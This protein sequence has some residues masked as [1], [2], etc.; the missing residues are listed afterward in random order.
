MA[1]VLS[2][3]HNETSL[4]LKFNPHLYVQPKCTHLE[5]NV[6]MFNA[7]M[8]MNHDSTYINLLHQVKAM[9][10]APWTI[11]E[12]SSMVDGVRASGSDF[13]AWYL[14]NVG[15][16]TTAYET[17]PSDFLETYKTWTYKGV[18]FST[19]VFAP[20]RNT[21]GVLN[22]VLTM[23]FVIEVLMPDG[24]TQEFPAGR[25]L[26][27]Y[28][29][30]LDIS[31]VETETV[32]GFAS[33]SGGIRA[34]L[35]AEDDEFHTNAEKFCN[36]LYGASQRLIIPF[37]FA[38]C[39][40]TEDYVSVSL[41]VNVGCRWTHGLLY[42]HS[43]TRFQLRLLEGLESKPP[44]H[45]LKW[46]HLNWDEH[47]NNTRNPIRESDCTSHTV[48]LAKIHETPDYI[49]RVV[50]D[51]H[52]LQYS[53]Q[54]E[55]YTYLK[56]PD[57]VLNVQMTADIGS[58]EQHLDEIQKTLLGTSNLFLEK[59]EGCK[60][61][62]EA[63]ILVKD[64]ITRLKEMDIGITTEVYDM[65]DYR[66]E[67]IT[68]TDALLNRMIEDGLYALEYDNITRPIHVT[69]RN[70]HDALVKELEELNNRRSFPLWAE[71][72]LIT[73][74]IVSVGLA[75]YAIVQAVRDRKKR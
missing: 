36:F 11:F 16:I 12:M 61:T 57:A 33:S 17:K 41:R 65:W 56:T 39:S 35:L 34:T 20:L 26:A 40:D 8:N 25:D 47:I 58:L 44:L 53:I 46:S 32:P 15:P 19:D 38:T 1:W 23:M 73:L 55:Y 64:I 18:E 14:K 52:H 75:S 29:L 10:R 54:T 37:D 68:D 63:C 69:R 42:Q 62:I 28:N 43:E 49:Q 72:V 59:A 45:R 13:N 2:Q 66:S 6:I 4:R 50:T 9:L 30:D 67:N 74:G 22:I 3:S 7:I 51:L 71:I 5:P 21:A 70:E 27:E 24:T 31:G 60:L 48:V